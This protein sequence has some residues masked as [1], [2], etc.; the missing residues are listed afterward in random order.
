MKRIFL[1]CFILGLVSSS[2]QNLT[3]EETI[4]YI[5]NSLQDKDEI[6]VTSDGYLIRTGFNVIK[7]SYGSPDTKYPHKYRVHISDLLEPEYFS[8][9]GMGYQING[10][11]YGVKIWCKG[12]KTKPIG[13]SSTI[14]SVSAPSCIQYELEHFGETKKSNRSSMGFVPRENTEYSAKKLL[15][16]FKHLFKLVKAQGYDKK[17]DDDPFAPQNYKGNVDGISK[18]DLT[19]EI[20]LRKSGGVYFIKASIKGYTKEFILDSGAGDVLISEEFEG[21]L[22]AARAINQSDYLS[23]ANYTIADGSIVSCKRVLVKEIKVG[24]VSAKNVVVAICPGSDTMLLGKSFLDKFPS[25]K[26]DNYKEALI[27]Y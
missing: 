2:G 26:I 16:A 8:T 14:S 24:N 25:W 15:N 17:I 6:R 11:S 12:K 21:Q 27:L 22:I 13:N 20:K 4:V 3:I 19:N 1:V 10:V 7:G 23:K 5:N 18:S 9:D